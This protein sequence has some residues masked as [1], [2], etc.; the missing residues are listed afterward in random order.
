MSLEEKTF[1]RFQKEKLKKSRNSSAFNLDSSEPGFLTHKGKLLSESNLEENDWPSSDDEDENLNKDVVNQL[2]FGGGFTKKE[3]KVTPEVNDSNE[4]TRPKNKAD[5]LQDIIMKSKLKKLEKKELKDEQEDTREKLDKD[6]DSLVSASALEFK[7]MKRDRSE[8]DDDEYLNSTDKFDEYDKALR[9]MA[10]D[11]KVKPTDRTK[12][13]EELALE[14]KLKLEELEAARLMRMNQSS[15]RYEIGEEG[16]DDIDEEFE[17]EY[18]GLGNG[19]AKKQKKLLLIRENK[20]KRR[21]DEKRERRRGLDKG[22]V[23][24]GHKNDD[25]LDVEAADEDEDDEADEC[26]DDDDD[27]DV[28]DEEEEGNSKSKGSEKQKRVDGVYCDEDVLVDE[29]YSDDDEDGED[30]DDEEEDDD[31]DD[32]G[33]DYSDENGNDEADDNEEDGDDTLGENNPTP[34]MVAARKK[35]ESNISK[36][37]NSRDKLEVNPDMPHNIP[38]PSDQEQFKSLLETYVSNVLDEEALLDRILIWN[39]LLLPNNKDNNEQKEKMHNFLDLLLHYFV[40]VG[41]TLSSASSDVCR[42]GTSTGSEEGSLATSE[43]KV[44]LGRVSGVRLFCVCGCLCL[45][46]STVAQND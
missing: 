34:R 35:K 4:V 1:L 39:S 13:P 41:N 20:R 25:E 37:I 43:E 32:E 2:H 11:V 46:T 33:G 22:R 26:D 36:K 27:D 8:K 38:C 6:F 7:P 30:E 19:I 29:E 3:T 9:E 18:D 44:V 28:D 42:D 15:K 14:A 5:I 40:S 21:E 12:A 10:Y 23:G 31:D 45:C 24:S 17:E 16:N